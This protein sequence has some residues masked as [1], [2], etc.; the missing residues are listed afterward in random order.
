MC[1][2]VVLLLKTLVK[3]QSHI[4]LKYIVYQIKAWLTPEFHIEVGC[5]GTQGLELPTLNPDSKNIPKACPTHN[6]AMS[7]ACQT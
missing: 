6:P 3:P 1:K 2:P 4:I 5:Q 7:P